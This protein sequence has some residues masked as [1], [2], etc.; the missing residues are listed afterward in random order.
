MCFAK[1]K[2]CFIR[3]SLKRGD[4]LRPDSAKECVCVGGGDGGGGWRR[5]VVMG[6]GGGGGWWGLGGASKV[7]VGY[8]HGCSLWSGVGVPGHWYTRHRGISL[9]MLIYMTVDLAGANNSFL[10][11]GYDFLSGRCIT[12]SKHRHVHFSRSKFIKYLMKIIQE[13][14]LKFLSCQPRKYHL[15]LYCSDTIYLIR[16]LP[17]HRARISLWMGPANGR[18]RYI[19]TSSLIGWAHT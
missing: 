1:K 2:K 12:A 15:P 13:I 9:V 4:F 16:K 11:K 6:V 10:C 18:R 17:V 8:D 19:V 5:R 7:K 14:P 3:S